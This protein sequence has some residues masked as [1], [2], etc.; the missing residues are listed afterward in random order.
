MKMR[1]AVL[2][3]ALAAAVPALCQERDPDLPQ[4]RQGLDK[5]CPQ[6]SAFA[7]TSSTSA[8]DFIELH[9]VHCFLNCPLYTVRVY[10][11]GRLV[12]HGDKAVTS[13]GDAAAKI[14]VGQA[15]ALISNALQLGFGSLCDEYVMQAFDGSTS[16]MSLSISG[17]VKTV[18]DTSPSNVPR[19]FYKLQQQIQSLDPVQN[20]I[21][22]KQAAKSK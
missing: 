10:G 20:W 8:D 2:V 14:D 4:M 11:D 9:R 19:W 5:G 13:M 16:A 18:T 6:S 7:Q 15:N 3:C 22:A 17:Q 21:G 12:W 1:L